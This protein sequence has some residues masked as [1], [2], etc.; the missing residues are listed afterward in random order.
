MPCIVSSLPHSRR[1][2]SLQSSEPS[3]SIAV[4][5]LLWLLVLVGS[6]FERGEQLGD[7]CF[8][9][10]DSKWSDIGHAISLRRRYLAC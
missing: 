10:G 4:R 1:P 5:E 3:R 2:R 7:G 8:G 6:C 9:H